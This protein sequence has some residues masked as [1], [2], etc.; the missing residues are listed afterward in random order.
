MYPILTNP[1]IHPAFSPSL[2][3]HVHDLAHIAGVAIFRLHFVSYHLNQSICFWVH[4][5][6]LSY[7]FVLSIPR[8][9]YFFPFFVI[10][11]GLL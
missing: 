5:F 3:T 10:I 2:M 4:L 11:F 8:F 7:P 6:S 1:A 9:F